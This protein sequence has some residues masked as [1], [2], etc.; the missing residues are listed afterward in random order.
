MTRSKHSLTR[1]EWSLILGLALLLLSILVT[2]VWSFKINSGERM[3]RDDFF[4]IE[5]G[6]K[7]FVQH[8]NRMPSGLDVTY[9][10]RFGL[11]DDLP[12]REVINVLRG[13][14]GDGN[15]GHQVNPEQN[16]FSKFN[17]A[18]PNKS[19]LSANGDLVDVWGQPYQIVLDMD[20]NRV[21]DLVDSIY[22]RAFGKQVAVWSYGPDG[23]A[24]T[25]DDLLSWER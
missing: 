12:N 4:A 6:V 22:D 9:D 11:P 8:Y 14:D 2:I 24:N 3:V 1:P 7:Y 5:G 13:V 20:G 15:Q 17:K 16:A 25:A 18:G 10:F 19:G 23:R 21:C